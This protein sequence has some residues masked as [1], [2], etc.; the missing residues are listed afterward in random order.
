M[1]ETKQ[2][3]KQVVF[4]SGNTDMND[5]QFMTYYA[6]QI[7]ELAN[8]PNVEFNIGDDE[9]CAL[10]VQMLLS[11]PDKFDKSRVNIFYMGDKI[12]NIVHKDYITI[13]G[14]QT[15]EERNAGMTLS[16]NLDYHIILEGKG[17]TMVGDNICR[18]NSP[19]Y[20]Y[21]KHFFTG[22]TPFWKLFGSANEKEG[23]N[24]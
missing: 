11:K 19:E 4:I 13:G 24:A 12:R 6:P 23:T 22:N 16:S 21:G 9:G 8:D 3:S 2:P 7:M 18:R 20:N 14:F 10:M 1:E 5:K 17:R 15:L